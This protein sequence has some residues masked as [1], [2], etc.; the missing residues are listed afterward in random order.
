[1]DFKLFVSNPDYFIEEI[2][3]SS[4]WGL[5]LWAVNNVLTAEMFH[6]QYSV[7]T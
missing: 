6:L 1:M 7:T 4:V 3:K 2:S 5:G